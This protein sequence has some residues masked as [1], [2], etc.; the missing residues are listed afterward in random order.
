MDLP[1]PLD[2]RSCLDLRIGSNFIQ[3]LEAI[4]MATTF[5]RRQETGDMTRIQEAIEDLIKLAGGIK[6]TG[7]S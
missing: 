2:E 4:S 6:D 5:R 7:L 3:C 1:S